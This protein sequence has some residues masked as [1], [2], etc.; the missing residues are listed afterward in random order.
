MPGTVS[1]KRTK[2][3]RCTITLCIISKKLLL[4][5]S[6]TLTDR[7][8]SFRTDLIDRTILVI[9]MLWALFT[10]ELRNYTKRKNVIGDRI[11]SVISREMHW[12]N[13]H[14]KSNVLL[15]ESMFFFLFICLKI[16]VCDHLKDEET[17]ARAYME[18]IRTQ[19]QRQVNFVDRMMTI[20]IFR[21]SF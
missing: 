19:E 21:F 14:S 6:L 7:F 18:F 20:L 3:S 4:S 9:R 5:S 13:M 10:N 17:A 15:D 11:V 8:V 1:V 12:R 16:S 2:L